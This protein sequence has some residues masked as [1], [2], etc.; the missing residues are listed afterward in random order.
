MGLMTNA[1]VLK[2]FSI[3]LVHKHQRTGVKM[4]KTCHLVI[5]LL[6]LAGEDNS[7]LKLLLQSTS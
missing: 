4:T 1:F 2:L 3:L 5:F 7:F 6:E